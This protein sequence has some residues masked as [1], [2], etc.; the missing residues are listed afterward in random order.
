MK[1]TISR[2]LL[3]LSLF[4]WL[5]FSSPQV[6][7]QEYVCT[8][9]ATCQ[10]VPI[11][12]DE[13]CDQNQCYSSRL[14][15]ENACKGEAIDVPEYNL[16]SFTND[17]GCEACNNNAG[18]WTAIGCLPA[19]PADLIVVLIR[20]AL[21]VGGGIA[22]LIMLIGTLQISASTGNPEQ[23]QAGQQTISA[24][25]LGLICIVFGATIL[26]IIG[27]DILDLPGLTETLSN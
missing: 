26:Q 3:V 18:V 12:D 16:C 4:T 6:E 14:A 9:Q 2:L 15:C 27:V 7:A 19:S 25:I 1:R 24:A 13:T 5:I 8:P 17:P 20:F 10:R 23:V 21:G 11:G 22:L